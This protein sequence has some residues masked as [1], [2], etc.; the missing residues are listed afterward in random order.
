MECK[1]DTDP[2]MCLSPRIDSP[3]KNIGQ[4]PR[5]AS[6]GM[7]KV[8]VYQS[9]QASLELASKTIYC[10]LHSNS[11]WQPIPFS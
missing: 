2:L 6:Q 8:G 7:T 4:Y 10:L 11:L 3:G 9:K 5:T 1:I